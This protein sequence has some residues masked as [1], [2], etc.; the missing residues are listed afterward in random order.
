MFLVGGEY[1]GGVSFE[2]KKRADCLFFPFF[3]FL[4]SFPN[5]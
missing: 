4:F 3:F 1:Q 5:Y 2:T